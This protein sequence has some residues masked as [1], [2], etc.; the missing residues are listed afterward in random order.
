MAIEAVGDVRFLDTD[1]ETSGGLLDDKFEEGVDAAESDVLDT[2]S[3]I[4]EMNGDGLGRRGFVEG[5]G[6]R[7]EDRLLIRIFRVLNPLS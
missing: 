3:S 2:R 4:L 1:A 5:G 6:V 7:N